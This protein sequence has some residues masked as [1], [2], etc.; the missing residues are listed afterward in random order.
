LRKVLFLWAVLLAA[1]PAARAQELVELL[2]KG[3]MVQV[4][5]DAKGKFDKATAVIH[6]DRPPADVWRVATD[7]AT[8]KTFLPKTLKSTPKPAGPNRV[9]VEYE[10]DTPMTNTSYTFRY[11]IDPDKMTMRGNWVKGD[12]KGSF[13]SWRLIPSGEGTLLYYTTAS[14]NFS[15]IAQRLEDDQQT[16]T[17]GVNVATALAVVK[18]MKRHVEGAADAGH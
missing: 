10:I 4:E 5:T 6:I 9:D 18:A 3:P 7:F 12:I 16:I 13:C 17:V 11:D 8:Y 1:A 15:S 2:A 14:R